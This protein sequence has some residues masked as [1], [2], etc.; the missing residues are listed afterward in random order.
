MK[1]QD[2]SDSDKSEQSKEQKKSPRPQLKRHL[3][4]EDL[5][6]YSFCQREFKLKH[7]E[8]D[9]E[10]IVIKAEKCAD[11]SVVWDG[12]PRIMM[13]LLKDFRSEDKY[14]YP[15]TIVATILMRLCNPQE[16]LKN[17]AEIERRIEQASNLKEEDPSQYYGVVKS[18]STDGMGSRMF[19][20]E[21]KSDR[22]KFA[23]KFIEPRSDAERERFQSEIGIMRM[24]GDD[25]VTTCYEA[26]D[27]KNRYWVVM[28]MME[29]GFITDMLKDRRGYSEEF[30]KYSLYQTL[31]CLCEFHRKNIIH[32]DIKSDNIIV[33][34]DGKFQ[35]TGFYYTTVLSEQRQRRKSKVGTIC[36]MAPELIMGRAEY[37]IKVD[38]WS[39]GI[40]AIELAQG[41]PPYI[42]DQQQRVLFNIVNRDPPRIDKNW[43]R[44]FQD[45]IDK[46]LDKDV[47][48]RWSADMLI[49]HPFLVGA[50]DM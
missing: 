45:F 34:E 33:D 42:N 13:S 46:C 11:G 5:K 21:R 20:C 1:T 2:G 48:K 16:A 26:F 4:L 38:C 39:L 18:L 14:N 27:F 32:R 49:N 25:Q 22:K 47:E 17:S 37:D 24:L 23:L 43:S 41:D 6:N 15:G 44:E 29:G 50:E 3:E 35:L 7:R 8:R 40:F 30:C 9:E 12:L 10:S 36:W 19:C 31:K 28:D